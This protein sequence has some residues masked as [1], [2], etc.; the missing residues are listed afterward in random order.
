MSPSQ[1][2]NTRLAILTVTKDLLSEGNANPS[3]SEIAKKCGLTKSALYYFFEN[4]KDLI[5]AVMQSTLEELYDGLLH[6]AKKKSDS[7]KN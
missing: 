7:E 5:H 1:E 4:K 2:K 3:M 6:I